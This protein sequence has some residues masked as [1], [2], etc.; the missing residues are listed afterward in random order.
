MKEDCMPREMVCRCLEPVNDPGFIQVVRGHFH[1]YAIA[2]G[3]A[4]EPLAH[5]ARNMSQHLMAVIQFG[6]EHCARQHGGDS[7]FN[8]DRLFHAR[9]T[10]SASKKAWGFGAP[11]LVD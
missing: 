9:S 10:E 5:P 8:F 11:R 4:Y 3:Q 6:A 7:S 1:L 2:D